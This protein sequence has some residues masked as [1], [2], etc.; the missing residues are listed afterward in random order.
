MCTLLPGF[1][2][3]KLLSEFNTFGI[4][5]RARYFIE[6]QE[7][8]QMQQVLRQCRS[9][10]LPYF[11][12]G[13]GSNCL[14]DD[15]GFDG[16]VILNK[17]HFIEN[18]APDIFHVGAGYPFSLLGIQTARQG[19][20]GL[21]FAS[22]IPGSI[23]GA[24]FMNAGANGSETC[25]PLMSVDFVSNDGELLTLEKAQLHFGYRKSPFQFMQGAIT[26]AAFRLTPSCQA[27]TNQLTLLNHRK[28]TQPL[29]HK[30]AG[31][32]FQN[33]ENGHAGMLI[34]QCGL[35]GFKVGG[36]QISEMHANFIINTGNATCR[37]VLML[38]EIIKQEV[39]EKKGIEL[40]SEVR[41]IPYSSI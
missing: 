33:P 23:G 24:I 34:E 18:R 29:S 12:L 32:V 25:Q 22:G 11:I 10:K 1:V 6:V 27:R 39:K 35:K 40:Q 14:F 8:I 13:R 16:L 38:M 37:D 19:W 31:C 28:Q 15:R 4:G 2:T 30:S 26:G 41:Y 9:Q 36:A 3:D 7:A 17:I 20:S 21:E 5:G